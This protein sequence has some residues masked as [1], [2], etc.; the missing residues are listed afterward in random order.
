[1]RGSADFDD[2]MI[3]MMML[4]IVVG[5]QRFSL[6]TGREN[7]RFLTVADGIVCEGA[8]PLSFLSLLSLSLLL[9]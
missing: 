4:T 1:M 9:L 3:L 2:T 5:G 6:P 8:A 7:F